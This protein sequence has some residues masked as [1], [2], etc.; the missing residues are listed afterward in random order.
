[1]NV[2]CRMQFT[3]LVYVISAGQPYSDCLHAARSLEPDTPVTPI[4]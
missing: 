1:M 3:G 2:H 4:K